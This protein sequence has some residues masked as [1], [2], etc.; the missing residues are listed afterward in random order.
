MLINKKSLPYKA[1][2]ASLGIAGAIGAASLATAAISV[3]TPTDVKTYK[4]VAIRIT[5]VAI[6][7]AASD[8]GTRV[9]QQQLKGLTDAV[10][11]F[12]VAV[13]RAKTQVKVETTRG[14]S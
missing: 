3:I 11:E 7:W 5:T 12:G 1:V 8:W 10:N 14:E 2:K 9:V 13:D 4:K 6:V